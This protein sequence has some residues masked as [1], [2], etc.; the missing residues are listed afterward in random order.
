MFLI[1]RKTINERTKT[2]DITETTPASFEP[3]KKLSFKNDVVAGPRKTLL[4]SPPQFKKTPKR[5]YLQRIPMSGKRSVFPIYM[6]ILCVLAIGVPIVFFWD[7][8]TQESPKR[9][10]DAPKV[11][12]QNIMPSQSRALKSN[13]DSGVGVNANSKVASAEISSPINVLNENSTPEKDSSVTSIVS[14]HQNNES[15]GAENIARIIARNVERRDEELPENH[16]VAEIDKILQEVDNLP[17]NVV[18][19]AEKN[20]TS[21]GEWRKFKSKKGELLLAKALTVN[22]DDVELLLYKS[23]KKIWT[24]IGIFSP[25][26]QDFLNEWTH[27]QYHATTGTRLRCRTHRRSTD[28]VEHWSTYYGSYDKTFTNKGALLIDAQ[29]L[30]RSSEEVTVKWYFLGKHASKEGEV[31]AY[32]GGEK[33]L[34][35]TALESKQFITDESA[36]S[37]TVTLYKALR[38]KYVSGGKY[39]GWV[40]ITENQGQVTSVQASHAPIRELHAAKHKWNKIFKP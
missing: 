2:N 28:V 1:I 11:I 26:D 40:A 32:G 14:F 6:G 29:N 3:S 38:E 15:Q 10:E 34:T 4:I 36:I 39:Y 31:F 8:N 33:Q 16:R 23:R 19:P 9:S 12:A 25:D 20:A 13:I 35:L 17:Q 37:S 21:T 18:N 27:S 24:K 5:S 22:D 7:S 30:R